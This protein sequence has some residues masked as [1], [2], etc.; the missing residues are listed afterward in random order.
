MT[1]QNR[2]YVG[3]RLN[4]PDGVVEIV[5]YNGCMSVKI[6]F[7]ETGYQIT[8]QAGHILR[9]QVRDKLKPTVYGKDFSGDGPHKGSKSSRAYKLW[10]DIFT[11]CYGGGNLPYMGCS[12][13]PQ[14]YNFQEFAEWCAWQRGFELNW[15]LDKD[16]LTPGNRIYSAQTC[17]FV[18]REMNN[19][20]VNTD[21]AKGY[22][23]TKSGGYAVY[24]GNKY[25]GVYQDEAAARLRYREG[26]RD[27]CRE[28]LNKWSDNLDERVVVAMLRDYEE[29]REAATAVFRKYEELTCYNS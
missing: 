6:K 13:D 28:L 3:K 8:T 4:T 21:N 9:G 1:E 18:P 29:K 12:I 22:S 10:S 15:H 20:Y 17:V 7:I 24:V 26:K 25:L 19:F 14:W 16:I 5:A 2:L 23:Q 27:K 11:R